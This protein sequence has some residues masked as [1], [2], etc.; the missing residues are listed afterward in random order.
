MS[1]RLIMVIAF[2][3]VLVC[4]INGE[5]SSYSRNLAAT[6]D[7][8]SN[9]ARDGRNFVGGMNGE[10]STYSRKLAVKIDPCSNRCRRNF[11]GL[12]EFPCPEEWK[13]IGNDRLASFENDYTINST[14]IHDKSNSNS[15]DVSGDQDS[16]SFYGFGL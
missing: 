12:N 13:F 1:P 10:M 16:T 6:I 14:E 5:R 7:P 11:D 9:G 2:M 3:V 4:G 15:L 8:C